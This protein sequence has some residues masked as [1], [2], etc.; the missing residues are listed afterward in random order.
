M[1]VAFHPDPAVVA[2]PHL[3]SAMCTDH[4]ASLT[5]YPV[6]VVG[7]YNMDD[8]ASTSGRRVR[9]HTY[10]SHCE[11][12]L[13]TLPS[14]FNKQLRLVLEALPNHRPEGPAPTCIEVLLRLTR[15]RLEES[16]V[17]R[18]FNDDSPSQAIPL[19]C[20]LL[21][22]PQPRS[23]QNPYRPSVTTD[24]ADTI[25]ALPGGEAGKQSPVRH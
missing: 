9:L 20:C 3:I 21:L 7:L 17:T 16:V 4:T 13:P 12:I 1:N 10:L 25:T 6:W 23:Y 22:R 18:A 15:A 14:S 5:T 19:G 11:H 8:G 24:S 2:S